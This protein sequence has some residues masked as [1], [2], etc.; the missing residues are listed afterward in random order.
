[1]TLEARL[2]EIDALLREAVA[3]MRRED[4][5]AG[6]AAL[7]LVGQLTDT[8]RELGQ[9]SRRPVSSTRTPGASSRHQP[10]LDLFGAAV[11]PPLDQDGEQARRK[12]ED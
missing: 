12:N 10:P 8:V 4:D 9:W 7:A 5:A 1:V 2:G 3:R 11:N 6:A